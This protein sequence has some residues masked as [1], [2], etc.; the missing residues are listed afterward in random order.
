MAFPAPGWFQTV[1]SSAGSGGFS[2]VK[3]WVMRKGLRKVNDWR[4]FDD[5]WWYKVKHSKANRKNYFSPTGDIFCIHNSLRVTIFHCYVDYVGQLFFVISVDLALMRHTAGSASWSTSKMQDWEH[6]DHP[7]SGFEF[8]G[9]I[10]AWLEDGR[11]FSTRHETRVFCFGDQRSGTDR[12]RDLF[13]ER[14]QNSTNE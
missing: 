3:L 6:C 8:V 14:A 12:R 4:W 7:C 5:L 1:R 9:F 2:A 13:D 10:G 11:G